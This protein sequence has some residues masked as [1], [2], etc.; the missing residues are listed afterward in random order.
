M[1][2][3]HNLLKKNILFTELVC[4]KQRIGVSEWQTHNIYDQVS[5]WPACNK[6]PTS[7]PGVLG[8]GLETNQPC[9]VFILYKDYNSQPGSE[10]GLGTKYICLL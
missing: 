1:C 10:C 5:A 3:S 6:L 2:P 4:A 7:V 9:K 8:Q